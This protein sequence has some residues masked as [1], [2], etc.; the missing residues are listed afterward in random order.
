MKKN[1]R[2]ELFINDIGVVS[3]DIVR[4]TGYYKSIEFKYKKK[5][6]AKTHKTN[7]KLVYQPDLI[8]TSIK[9]NFWGEIFRIEG[10]F[11]DERVIEEEKMIFH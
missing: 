2:K 10:E 8:A 7:F 6:L 3:K 5:W 9:H 11:K 1:R 4:L